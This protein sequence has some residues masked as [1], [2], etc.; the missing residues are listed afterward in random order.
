M[1]SR[2][3]IFSFDTLQTA[4][5]R[6]PRGAVLAIALIAIVEATLHLASA[7]LPQPVLWGSGESSA[8]VAQAHRWVEQHDPPL[9]VLI[10]GPSHGSV[11]ISPTVMRETWAAQTK[12]DELP[13]VYNG[14]LN[15]RNYPVLEF[16]FRQVYMPQLQPRLLVIAVS[17]ITFNRNR[18][19]LVNNTA[20]FFEAPMPKALSA[21]GIERTWRLFL[22]QHLALYRY[23]SRARG[24]ADGIIGGR[25]VLDTRGFHPLEDTFDDDDRRQLLKP[26]HP[27]HNIW[28]DYTFGGAAADAFERILTLARQRGI[29]VAVV[30]MPFRPALFEVGG[31]ATIGY[32]RYLTA[33]NSRC[34]RFGFKWLDYHQQ[35]DLDAQHFRDVDHLNVRGAEELSRQLA[36]DLTPLLPK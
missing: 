17:P 30:N 9:D 8:K 10:L 13:S 36:R 32:D 19:L 24:L 20:E 22:A 5:L 12:R 27:Y 4:S 35:L 11:G 29:H 28:A 2:S 15:G 3:S 25:Q 21:A 18:P 16:I 14:A 1:P 23:R 31:P 6:L 26:T 34:T 7:Y 33:M